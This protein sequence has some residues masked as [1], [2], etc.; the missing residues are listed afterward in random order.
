MDASGSGAR[1]ISSLDIILWFAIV[2]RWSQL[3]FLFR[4]VECHVTKTNW[5]HRGASLVVMKKAWQVY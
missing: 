5:A 2:E 4:G 3:H 1:F